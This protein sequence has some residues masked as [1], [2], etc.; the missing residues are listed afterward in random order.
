MY[1]GHYA[2][3]LGAKKIAPKVSLGTLFM[4]AII[5]DLIMSILMLA[6]IEHLRIAPGFTKMVPFDLYDFAISHSLATSVLWSLIFAAIY[7]LIIHSKRGSVV[8]GL[9]VFSHWILDFITHTTDLALFPGSSIK[10][11]LGIWNNV[12]VSILIEGLLFI[13]GVLIYIRSTSA[14]DK[15]GII[16]FWCVIIFLLLTWIMSFFGS[17]PSNVMVLPIS[18]QFQWI[19]I[20][21]A[22]WINRHREIV[23]A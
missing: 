16:A 14:K 11:G 10:V 12:V 23:A 1:I 8:I 20:L 6:G 3:A 9:T 18:N 4:A 13:I 7:Y 21:L 5:I 15:I 22:F 19:I 2:I 17:V